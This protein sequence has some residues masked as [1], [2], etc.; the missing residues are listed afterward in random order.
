MRLVV[1]LSDRGHPGPPVANPDE[2][3][4]HIPYH[5]PGTDHIQS[6]QLVASARYD[7][8]QSSQQSSRHQQKADLESESEKAIAALD[9]SELS[10]VRLSIRCN[11]NLVSS[12]EY[13]PCRCAIFVDQAQK[14]FSSVISPFVS[15]SHLF[16]RDARAHWH[17]TLSMTLHRSER[18]VSSSSHSQ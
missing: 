7:P 10:A 17:D 8:W 5:Q 1:V 9:R 11:T 18:V 3:P 2:S 16:E 15:S 4:R 14:N 13:F 12:L 6:S